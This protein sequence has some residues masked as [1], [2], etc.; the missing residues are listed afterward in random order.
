MVL[1]Q[2]NTLFFILLMV[3]FGLSFSTLIGLI[4]YVIRYVNKVGEDKVQ[5]FNNLNRNAILHGIVFLGDS[6]TEFYPVD[7]FFYGCDVYNRGIAGDT[8]DGVLK[9]LE[10]NV[11]ILEP[12]KLFLQIGTNDLGKRKPPEYIF[13]NIKKIIETIR[14]RLPETQLYVISLYPVNAKATPYSKS[15]MLGRKNTDIHAINCWLN[16][17]CQQ[18]QLP[19]LDVASILRDE[20]GLLKKEYTVEGLHISFLGYAAITEVLKPY[21]N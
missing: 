21:V 6:L 2:V 4:F 8:T 20:N 1:I 14:T 9:R 5:I 18:Q 17:Y 15:I 7:E 13:N 16:T 3:G 12:S 10:N 11:L 19:Y